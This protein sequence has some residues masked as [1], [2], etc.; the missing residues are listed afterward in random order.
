MM[1]VA[2]WQTLSSKRAR[3]ALRR[4]NRQT[5]II[6]LSLSITTA[7]FGVASPRANLV[8]AFTP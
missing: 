6:L 2:Q 7:Q 4:V 3:Y 5:S 1:H 8:A